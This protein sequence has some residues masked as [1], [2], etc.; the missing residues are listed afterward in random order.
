[1][2]CTFLRFYLAYR[3]ATHPQHVAYSVQIS[4]S[5]YSLL[6]IKHGLTGDVDLG[7]KLFYY[8]WGPSYFCVPAVFHHFSAS[9]FED[10]GHHTARLKSLPGQWSLSVE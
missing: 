9:V 4:P 6:Y 3:V 5:L 7:W 10:R 1:M 2:C 8:A